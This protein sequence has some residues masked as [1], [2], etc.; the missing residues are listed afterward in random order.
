M[1][2]KL[3]TKEF[4]EKACKIHGNKFNY[5]KVNYI[6]NSTKVIITV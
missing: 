6:N 2:K 1:N 5:S 4:V 3:T